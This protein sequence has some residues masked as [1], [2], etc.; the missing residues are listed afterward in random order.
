RPARLSR[1][2]ARSRDEASRPSAAISAPSR[3]GASRVRETLWSGCR[4]VQPAF[5]WRK[6]FPATFVAARNKT[7]SPVLGATKNETAHHRPLPADR[8][9][10]RSC[11]GGQSSGARAWARGSEVGL[12]PRHLER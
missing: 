9:A 1:L 5:S 7:S 4:V 11:P 12:L 2:R 8:G 6:C 10:T 3:L